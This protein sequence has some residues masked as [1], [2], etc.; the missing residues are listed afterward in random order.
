MSDINN[1]RDTIIAK[2]DQLNADDLTGGTMTITVTGVRRGDS[3]QPVVIHYAGDNGRPYKPCKTMRRVLIAGWTENG[4]AWIGRSMTLYNDPKVKFGGVEIGGI[5]IS[6]MTDIGNGLR[7]TPNAA[8]G[9]KA[10]VLIKPLVIAK[11]DESALT[12][13]IDAIAKSGTLDELK[14]AARGFPKT[15]SDEHKARVSQAY[16]ERKNCLERNEYVYAE[17]ADRFDAEL[18]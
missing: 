10:E 12:A 5:R 8:K 2:S 9:K 18:N 13:C 4:S 7:L 11:V 6:H 17:E 14:S 1:L 15:M 3:D 16:T